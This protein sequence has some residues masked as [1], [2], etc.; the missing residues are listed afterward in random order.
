MIWKNAFH[1]VAVATHTPKRRPC[2]R[3]N[4]LLRSFIASTAHSLSLYFVFGFLCSSSSSYLTIVCSL[5]CFFYLFILFS[6]S[7]CCHIYLFYMSELDSRHL[8]L[9]L[10]PPLRPAVGLFKLNVV[11]RLI[12]MEHSATSS[13]SS[14]SSF[15]LLPLLKCLASCSNAASPALA[16]WRKR[17]RRMR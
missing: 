4:L 12:E 15:C 17:E 3:D 7:C 1:F 10:S 11:G 16:K 2:L 9:L 14:S 13:S 6:R 5:Y 8:S